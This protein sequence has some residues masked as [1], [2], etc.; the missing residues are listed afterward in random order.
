M[1]KDEVLTY[2]GRTITVAEVLGVS[3]SAVCQWKEIIP[4]KNALRLHQITNG[5]LR[6]EESLYRQA[7]HEDA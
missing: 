1:R 2:F 7:P 5:V 3:H 6:Y 4:E